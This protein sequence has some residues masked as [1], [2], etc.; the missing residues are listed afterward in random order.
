MELEVGSTWEAE[1]AKMEE[2]FRNEA[3]EAQEVFGSERA[4]LLAE[5]EKLRQEMGSGLQVQR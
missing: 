5:I 1:K 4:G 2:K 3:R